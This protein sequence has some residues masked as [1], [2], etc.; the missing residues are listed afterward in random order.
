ME[1]FEKL[2]EEILERAHKKKACASEYMKAFR[3]STAEEFCGIIK[4]NFIWCI[5]NRTIN[6]ELIDKYKDL[7]RVNQIYHNEDIR[8][9]FGIVTG[10]KEVLAN[11]KIVFAFDDAIVNSFGSTKVYA[12]DN[13]R[14]KA[15]DRSIVCTYNN[16]KV[17]SYNNSIINAND[18]AEVESYNES[19][20]R[21][22]RYAKV[23]AFGKSVVTGFGNSSICA[24]DC[25]IVYSHSCCNVKASG[26]SYVICYNSSKDCE[27]EGDAICR[28][29][30]KRVLKYDSNKLVN[31]R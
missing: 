20:V 18:D 27:I 15:H 14:V 8:D 10:S 23:K 13:S 4:H 22:F 5:K 31:Y 25:S 11:G 30:F 9:G 7:F 6:G 1:E 17:K 21:A 26:D 24:H 2:K 29:L 28:E 19:N 12:F 16:S 3:S